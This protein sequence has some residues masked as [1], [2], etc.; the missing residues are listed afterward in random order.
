VKTG[1]GNETHLDLLSGF[2]R[3]A[4]LTAMTA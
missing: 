3:K 1:E 4:L 2:R